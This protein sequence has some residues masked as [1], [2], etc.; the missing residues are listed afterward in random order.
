VDAGRGVSRVAEV[1]EA[2]CAISWRCVS[3]S[4]AR[5]IEDSVTHGDDDWEAL[6][7]T[8]WHRLSQGIGHLAFRRSLQARHGRLTRHSD[9][10]CRAG[11]RLPSKRILQSGRFCITRGALTS[12]VDTAWPYLQDDEA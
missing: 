5:A 6:V 9:F 1:S 12:S 3:I 8:T 10:P 11:L 4:N 2:D 7:L